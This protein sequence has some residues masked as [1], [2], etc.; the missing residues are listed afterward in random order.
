MDGSTAYDV[1]WRYIEAKHMTITYDE[2]AIEDI[3]SEV[4]TPP[5]SITGQPLLADRVAASGS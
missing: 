3:G 1:G 4:W 5:P 2:M